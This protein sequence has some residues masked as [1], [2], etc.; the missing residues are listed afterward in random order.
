MLGKVIVFCVIIAFIYFF[1][2]PKFV[3]KKD[4]KKIQNFVECQKCKTYVDVKDAV[5]S[6]GKYICKDC[7]KKD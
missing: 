6:S 7:M 1:I 2:L 3:R 4:D 5:I